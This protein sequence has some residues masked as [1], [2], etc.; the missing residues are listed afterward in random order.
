MWYGAA[1]LGS[2]RRAGEL[3][4]NLLTSSVVRAEGATDGF[5]QIQ[6]RQIDAFR[7]VHP[8]GR[9]SQ[10]LVVVPTDGAT[11]EQR[12]RYAAY[13]AARTPRTAKPQGPAG[14]LF[15]RD[16]VGTSAEIAE[17]L[18]DHAGFQAVDEVVFA[19]PFDFAPEDYVQILT[20]I[21]TRLAPEL[22]WSPHR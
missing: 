20:D 17:Q 14:M 12:A 9:V 2:A 7:A 10:G 6:R 1:S 19:L 3:G 15:A 22:G 18:R 4:M 13:A 5:A 8:A 11:S 21:A 16:L